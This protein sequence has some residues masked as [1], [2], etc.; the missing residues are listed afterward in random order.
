MLYLISNQ[1]NASKTKHMKS[2]TCP[3]RQ[4]SKPAQ[5]LLVTSFQWPPPTLFSP[6]WYKNIW[7]LIIS[8]SFAHSCP[9]I[10]F[11]LIL[12]PIFAWKK[13]NQVPVSCK[14]IDTHEVLI[15]F[16]LFFSIVEGWQFLVKLRN[17]VPAEREEVFTRSGSIIAEETMKAGF[18]H[19]K[20]V[21]DS[22]FK[23]YS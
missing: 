21:R 15:K 5:N 10:I 23:C 14:E 8:K 19:K 6:V 17:I 12:K 18:G 1:Q 7:T 2:E 4:K 11:W 9:Y 3:C 13:E 16:K 20:Q 22:W